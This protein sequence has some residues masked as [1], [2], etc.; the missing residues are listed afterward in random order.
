MTTDKKKVQ[1]EYKKP[2]ILKKEK[3]HVC[4]GACGRG[5][6]GCGQLVARD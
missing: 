4:N 6:N 1:R 3:S 5:W 2:A